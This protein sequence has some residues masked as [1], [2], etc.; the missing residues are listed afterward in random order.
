MQFNVPLFLYCYE[1]ESIQAHQKDKRKQNLFM[2]LNLHDDYLS[3]N[4]S[5]IY[6]SELNMKVTYESHV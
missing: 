4:K 6:L 2:S 1:A 5:Y 3:F